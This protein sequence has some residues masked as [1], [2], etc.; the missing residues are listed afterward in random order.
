M[1]DGDGAGSTSLARATQLVD[2][3]LKA[4]E[5]F[6]RGDL[7]ARMSTVRRGLADPSVHI[8]VAGEFKQGK[9][10]LVNGLVGATVCP[11]DD[12]VAT[13]L[14]TYVR[15]GDTAQAYLLYDG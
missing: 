15:H 13:A 12:D 10:S 5:A 8:V 4:C 1:A 11:V 14:P 3:C 6:G 7:A 9:S 2:L